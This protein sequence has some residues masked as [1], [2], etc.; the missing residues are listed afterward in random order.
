MDCKFGMPTLI[1]KDTILDNVLLCKELNL[2]FVE[3]NMNLPYCMLDKNKPKEML[4]L[5]EEY[6]INFTF[7]RGN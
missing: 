4:K 1:E 3:L 2:H 5:K 6:K 7:S